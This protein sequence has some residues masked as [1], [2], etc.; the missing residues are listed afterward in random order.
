MPRLKLS[1]REE[2]N[3]QALAAISDYMTV[4][5]YKVTKGLSVMCGFSERTAR[6]RKNNPDDLKVADLRRMK[7]LSDSQI[8]RIVKGKEE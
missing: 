3:R 7:G 5:G 1:D 8:L 2:K 6:D 4:R